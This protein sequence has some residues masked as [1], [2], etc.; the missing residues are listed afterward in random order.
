LNQET[1]ELEYQK[2]MERQVY[3]FDDEMYRI[4]TEE[5][6]LVVS[7]EHKVYSADGDLVSFVVM[8]EENENN[9]FV[10]F[11]DSEFENK[12][13]SDMNS[14]FTSKLVPQGFVMMGVEDDLV[15]LFSNNFSEKGISSDCFIN[16]SLAAG[17]EV[18]NIIHLSDSRNLLEDSYP[19]GDSFLA[20]SL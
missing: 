14:F 11:V 7:P 20:V 1:G 17:C 10:L 18:R 8:S 6:E 13:L 16:R 9:S 12:T 5:G 19:I 3:D 15:N 2:P 4:E